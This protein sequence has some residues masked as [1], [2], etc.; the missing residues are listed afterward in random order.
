MR[1]AAAVKG[2]SEVSTLRASLH[3]GAVIRGKNPGGSRPGVSQQGLDT[4]NLLNDLFG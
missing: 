3:A 4:V 1:G 2:N